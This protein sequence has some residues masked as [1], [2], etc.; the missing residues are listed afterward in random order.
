MHSP[1]T[2]CLLAVATRPR[3]LDMFQSFFTGYFQEGVKVMDPRPGGTA[4]ALVAFRGSRC[5]RRI[6]QELSEK[7][8]LARPASRRVGLHISLRKLGPSTACIRGQSGSRQCRLMQPVPKILTCVVIP[9][10]RFR[11][12]FPS[13]SAWMALA[14]DEFYV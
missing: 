1:L 8:V 3:T 10:N 9:S 4:S 12:P 6:V 11:V 14:S 5:D 2:T 13:S 7:L